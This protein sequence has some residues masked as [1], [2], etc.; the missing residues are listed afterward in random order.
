MV[1]EV[2]GDAPGQLADRLHF[3]GLSKLLFGPLGMLTL[4][5]VTNIALDDLLTIHSID[6]A[7]ELHAD[8]LPA[9]C[10]ERQIFVTD[11]PSSL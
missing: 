4:R 2:M 7:Y 6:I 10:P 5:N 1:V 3:L 8:G 11:I 9:F